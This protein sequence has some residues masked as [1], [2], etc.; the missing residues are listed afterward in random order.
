METLVENNYVKVLWG[1]GVKKKKAEEE[2]G[3][4][5]F[6]HILVFQFLQGIHSEQHAAAFAVA[7][8]D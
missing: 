4:L 8:G 1:T 6:L 2:A 5:S 7:A 3:V